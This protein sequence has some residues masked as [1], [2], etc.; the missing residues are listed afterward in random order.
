MRVVIVILLISVGVFGREWHIKRNPFVVSKV[1]MDSTGK[2]YL[3]PKDTY[4]FLDISARGVF[5]KDGIRRV[6]LDL[7]ERGFITVAEGESVQI[8]TA[9]IMSTIKAEKITQRYV[10]ISINGAEATR[11]ELK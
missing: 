8:D 4:A 1:Y 6:L 11:Y 9:D 7:K 3:L 10:L 2:H 5:F